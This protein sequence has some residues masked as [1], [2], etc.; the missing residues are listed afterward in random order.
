MD[1]IFV[2]NHLQMGGSEIKTVTLANALAGQGLNVGVACLN[3]PLDL[4]GR[5]L[6]EIQVWT[7]QRRGKFS[8]RA[9]RQLRALVRERRPAALLAVNLYPALYVWAAVA[10]ARRPPRTV[11]LVNTMAHD[12]PS[13]WRQGMYRQVLARLDWTAYGCELQRVGWSRGSRRMNERSGVIYNGVDLE[14]WGWEPGGCRLAEQA[15]KFEAESGRTRGRAGERMQ[16]EMPATAMAGA[17]TPRYPGPGFGLPPGAFVVGT[18]GR[19]APEKN[20]AALIDAAAVLDRTGREIH[21]LL[22]GEGACRAALEERARARG[23]RDRV[24]FTGALQDVGPALALMD[25]FVLPSRLETFSNAA[26]EAMAMRRPVILSRVGGAAEM[27]RDGIDGYLVDCGELDEALPRVLVRL[28]DEGAL[29]LR[30]G[31]AARRRVEAAFSMERMVEDYRML[32]T[33]GTARSVI[34]GERRDT[35]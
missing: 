16:E 27:L 4:A 22:V 8:G 35:A 34:A 1:A 26:L 12:A 15:S 23:L 9:L 17:M 18:V 29:R 25:V 30:M 33:S 7:L 10:G 6:P 21:V 2:L 19:L 32:I 13:G 20:Q 31:E 14:A 11:G 28:H 3:E 24:H 5:L